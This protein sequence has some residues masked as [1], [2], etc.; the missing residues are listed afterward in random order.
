[1][2]GRAYE[3]LTIAMGA[4]A[5]LIGASALAA[6]MTVKAP[7]PAAVP[8]YGWTGFYLGGNI[9]Y[10]WGNADTDF[11][12]GPV[13]VFEG[14]TIPGFVMS[15]SV[16]TEGII[17]GGQIGYNS[18]FSA[19]W[20]AG[21]EVDIEGSGERASRSFSNPFFFDR[22]LLRGAAVT[23]YEAEIP[24]IGTARGRIGY[25]WDRV[26]LYVTGG[27]AYGEVKLQGTHTVRASGALKP[28]ISSALADCQVNTGWTVGAG[29]EAALVGNWTW[30]TEYLY[31]DLGSL[32]TPPGNP[33]VICTRC[34][35]PRL[36]GGGQIASRTNFTD[37]LVHVGLNYK[38]Y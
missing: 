29:V 24:W 1:L 31:V 27:L 7:V 34:L 19:N 28:F 33:A 13:T 26:M 21:L 25:A 2:P 16:K 12:A 38:F 20:V 11:D 9:G 36:A 15:E 35:P 14:P 32:D 17:G 22:P 3:K 8:A 4:A 30:K 5:A 6:D 10:S 37:N 23:E 18:R